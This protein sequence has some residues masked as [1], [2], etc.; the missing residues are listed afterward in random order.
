MTDR[1]QSADLIALMGEV[2][3]DERAFGL[4]NARVFSESKKRYVTFGS[5]LTKYG[6]PRTWPEYAKAELKEQPADD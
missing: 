1:H 4:L 2:Q 5:V 6:D 3:K